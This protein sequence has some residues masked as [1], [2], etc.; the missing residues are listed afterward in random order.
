MSKNAP[1]IIFNTRDG[2]N[3]FITGVSDEFQDECH[4]AMIHENMNISLLMVHDKKVEETMAK[5]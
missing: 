3:R 2:I 5:R 4:S 1:S